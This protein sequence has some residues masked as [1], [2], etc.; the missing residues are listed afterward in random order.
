[1][2]WYISSYWHEIAAVLKAWFCPVLWTL[3]SPT[4]CKSSSTW[5]SL[6]LSSL[7][8]LPPSLGNW[9]LVPS[10]LLSCPTPWCWS[11][12]A[13]LWP[14]NESAEWKDACNERAP[15]MKEWL[16]CGWWLSL[17]VK[18]VNVCRWDVF[19]GLSKKASCSL[20]TCIA[21]DLIGKIV[22]PPGYESL[23]A[24]KLHI[25]LNDFD[26]LKMNF[27]AV[28]QEKMKEWTPHGEKWRSEPRLVIH[29]LSL[30]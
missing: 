30:A 4:E 11:S 22:C 3:V 24:K 16:Q 28:S 5:D 2:K 23:K 29:K 15:A 6:V 9:L 13:S 10:P 12:S 1:M 27:L 25:G 7:P 26:W 20:A 21:M 19:L 8:S 14:L 18:K 17:Q